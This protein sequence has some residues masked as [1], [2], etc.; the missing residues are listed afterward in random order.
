MNPWPGDPQTPGDMIPPQGA[1][2]NVSL[3]VLEEL[4]EA[5]VGKPHGRCRLLSHWDRT[6]QLRT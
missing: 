6:Q 4:D 2:A 5:M 1:R 3:E